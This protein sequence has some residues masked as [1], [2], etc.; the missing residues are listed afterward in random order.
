MLTPEQSHILLEL[1]SRQTLLF[2]ATTLGPEFLSSQEKELLISHGVNPEGLYEAG[3]DLT[4]LNFHLGL[5]S[6]ILSNPATQALTYDQL[7]RYVQSGQHIPLNKREIETLNS[8]KMQSMADLRASNG[9]IFQDVNNVVSN[10]LST[11]RANQEAFLRDQIVEG[12][13]RR[14]SRKKIARNIAKLTGDWSR[15]FTKSVQ[16]IS[17]TALN[18]GRAA[19]IYRK[20]GDSKEAKVYFSVLAGACQY[21]IKSYLTKGEGSE[22]KI[23][24]L[25]EIEAN[26]SNIGRKTAEWRATL[27]ALH[28]NCRCTVQEYHEGMVWQGDRFVWPKGEKEK[29]SHR[30]KIRIVVN[31]QEHWV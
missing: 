19:M 2:S 20:H 26:G 9:R 23:F 14:E 22:P 16:Y 8:I 7:Y 18:E 3:K 24:T 29:T 28:V 12:N 10:E 31:G 21:C 30:P 25:A 11:A 15:N 6:G 13:E 5:L 17:H 27:S 4:L 1:I